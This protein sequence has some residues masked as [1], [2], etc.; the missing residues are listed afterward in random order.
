[1]I[2]KIS[3]TWGLLL[4]G[5]VALAVIGGNVAFGSDPATKTGTVPPVAQTVPTGALPALIGALR[6]PATSV[7]AVSPTVRNYFA[8]N[9]SAHRAGIDL[10]NLHEV[11]SAEHRF[12][13]GVGAGGLCLF[14][15]DGGSFC[16]ADIDG[17]KKRGL[18]VSVVP[19]STNPGTDDMRPLYPGASVVTYGIARDGVTSVEGQTPEGL[20]GDTPLVN[21]AYVL[22]T[23]TPVQH[24]TFHTPGGSWSN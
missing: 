16:T 7:A 13:V 14:L 22:T 9:D 4:V 18:E 23:R 10:A 1:M 3:R 11:G 20:T 21:N 19:T 2:N 5:V 8:F 15:P 6:T 24:I 12:Y 17:I